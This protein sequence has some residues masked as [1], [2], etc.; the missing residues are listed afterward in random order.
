MPPTVQALAY[1]QASEVLQALRKASA[2][3]SDGKQQGECRTGLGL[4][5]TAH[6]ASKALYEYNRVSFRG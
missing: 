4:P 5:T 3:P 2:C 1:T 6:P